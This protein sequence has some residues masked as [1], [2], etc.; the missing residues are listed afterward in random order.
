MSK[1][2]AQITKPL[3]QELLEDTEYEYDIVTHANGTKVINIDDALIRLEPTEYVPLDWVEY[4]ALMK[5]GI[6]RPRKKKS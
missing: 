5:V 4:T 6:P 2:V 1:I 3:V